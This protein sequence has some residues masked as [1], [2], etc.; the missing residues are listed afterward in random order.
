[1]QKEPGNSISV[2]VPEISLEDYR[3]KLYIDPEFGEEQYSSTV[4]YAVFTNRW[5]IE[6]VKENHS[7][8]I[9]HPGSGDSIVLSFNSFKDKLAFIQNIY[10]SCYIEQIGRGHN[11]ESLANL[12]LLYAEKKSS[13]ENIFVTLFYLLKNVSVHHIFPKI[14]ADK[15]IKRLKSVFKKGQFAN[16]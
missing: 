15:I 14:N 1:M 5:K 10:S 8:R 7:V 9:V 11:L 4:N 16:L 3:N 12:N 13:E 2:I 6:D